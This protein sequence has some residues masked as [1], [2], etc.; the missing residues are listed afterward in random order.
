[1]DQ[2]VYWSNYNPFAGES[3]GLHL[4]PG[5]DTVWTSTDPFGEWGITSG[6]FPRRP[7]PGDTLDIVARKLGVNVAQTRWIFPDTTTD[8]VLHPL[9]VPGDT[10]KGIGWRRT[11]NVLF[12]PDSILV[13]F[14]RNP[15]NKYEVNVPPSLFGNN[16]IF[17]N[18]APLGVPLNG[19][20]ICQRGIKRKADSVFVA[21]TFTIWNNFWGDAMK[22]HG[23]FNTW[24]TFVFPKDT[25]FFDTIPPSIQHT[26]LQDTSYAGPYSISAIITDR[27]VDTSNTRLKYKI[28]NGP[29]VV[30]PW[31]NRNGDTFNFVIPR[32]DDTLPA[33]IQYSIR[34]Q[35]YK[36]Y[37]QTNKAFWPG[38]DSSSFH[39]FNYLLRDI[40][41]KAIIAPD[42]IDSIPFFVPQALIK[43]YGNVLVSAPVLFK[44]GNYTSQK[45]I[46]LQPY[47]STI[48]AFDS[49]RLPRGWHAVKC[50]TMLLN[51][52][53]PWNDKK[54][55]SIFVRVLDFSPLEIMLQDTLDSNLVFI[56]SS[57]VTNKGNTR[58]SGAVILKIGNYS[59]TQ[60]VSL[61][62]N[63]TL[64]VTYKPISNL[65]RG[66][67]AVKCSTALT[68]DMVPDNDAITKQVF[69][70]VK[71]ASS[72][73]IS[74]AGIIDSGAVVVPEA[75]ISNSGNY[76]L[77]N[78]LTKMEIYKK[79]N[80]D[81]VVYS[82]SQYVSLD[83]GVSQEIT[84]SDFIASLLGDHFAKVKVFAPGDMVP[85]NDSSI[86]SFVVRP[87]VGWFRLPDLP[88]GNKGVKQG[89]S[90]VYTPFGIYAI[91]GNKTSEFYKLPLNLSEWQSM[92]SIPSGP[93]NRYP[94]FGA[95]LT[96]D[97]RRNLLYLMK[98]NNT[99]EFLCYDIGQN[100]WRQLK[101]VPL[102]FYG[103]KVKGG[104]IGYS[105]TYDIV[106]ALKSNTGE[107]YS[108][109]PDGDSWVSKKKV[110]L[111]K[112]GK[113]SAF[114][115]DDSFAYL[116]V[117]KTNE[118]LV[119]NI[120][121]D[122]WQFKEALPLIGISGKK[123]KVKFG[124]ATCNNNTLYVLK[125]GCNEFWLYRNGWLQ[126]E[127]MPYV[128]KI[129][130]AGCALTNDGRN[131][132]ALK[133][134]NT[135]EVWY[136]K[137]G[138]QDIS[139]IHQEIILTTKKE[140]M[141][142]LNSCSAISTIVIRRN[143]SE[144]LPGEV[145]NA[146]GKK[147]YRKPTKSGVYF[148]KPKGNNRFLKIIFPK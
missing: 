16:M 114:C 56:P 128:N 106:L 117:Q 31:S 12:P 70:R 111:S 42:T 22:G 64:L 21:D 35:D 61:N 37:P 137:P 40:G 36:S 49:L 33:L 39:N 57:K 129:V 83:P 10:T 122:T 85:N 68:N 2:Y 26:G 5:N 44:A 105:L 48:A 6:G 88:S 25:L 104:G 107:F 29:I 93:T 86:A 50:T 108:Y 123:K 112:I 81:S 136:Y 71:D 15:G 82:D 94:A 3:I 116:I 34:T 23:A 127:D 130:K 131:I 135:L 65:S 63:E 58:E 76:R 13:W 145:Y 27:Q 17:F 91:K 118:F 133:G 142:K 138:I 146:L 20:T 113:G 52:K 45:T 77:E 69:V 147:I 100:S 84:F 144:E 30:V 53:K 143:G 126:L 74:P 46:T 115:V 103:K 28:N 4:R 134:N 60:P 124:A 132:F 54:E 101:N 41:T 24:D 43:N 7:N 75:R 66:L 98:G 120:Q 139:K 99:L 19:D 18:C 14:A 72:Q 121:N 67:H 92:A 47:D 11:N 125:G 97:Q 62:P 89:G 51:D 78:I 109:Y 8:Q 87:L 140:E 95:S 32:V 119:Y 59:D 1:L 141:A 110:P 55:D 148:I 79:S 96:F 102:G 9:F 73:V 80:R 38:P 90:I